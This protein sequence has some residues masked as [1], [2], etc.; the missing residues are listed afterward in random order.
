MSRSAW[1]V[2]VSVLILGA[3]AASAAASCKSSLCKSLTQTLQAY[4]DVGNC[5][6][7]Y[8]DLNHADD[9]GNALVEQIK[10]VK[11]DKS[12]LATIGAEAAALADYVCQMSASGP[13]VDPGYHA[14]AYF[15]NTAFDLLPALKSLQQ[16]AG[17]KKITS[18]QFTS[19]V[20]IGQEINV[21]SD[22]K[23]DI[24]AVNTKAIAS[25]QGSSG[26]F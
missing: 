6:N 9:K 22:I 21:V 24:K 20:I 10:K 18:C 8:A 19:S 17:L 26:P 5:E 16:E 14:V 12:E 11:I 13:D 3:Q 23:A 1:T 15:N 7:C 25:E 2:V 4:Q